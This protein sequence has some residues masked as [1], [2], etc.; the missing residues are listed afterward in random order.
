MVQRKRSQRKRSR[1][2]SQRNQTGGGFF[3]WYKTVKKD[4]M[5]QIAEKLL[6][7]RSYTN[8]TD[9]V[10]DYNLRIAEHSGI[11][12]KDGH[13][14]KSFFS[15]LGYSSLIAAEVGFAM[16]L[17]PLLKHSG[18][19]EWLSES[20][21]S[22]RNII[23]INHLQEGL[24]KLRVSYQKNKRKTQIGMA[25][26]FIAAITAI[27]YHERK[28]KKSQSKTILEVCANAWNNEYPNQKI[29]TN[30]IKKLVKKN[31]HSRTL[32]KNII[33]KSPDDIRHDSKNE[34]RLFSRQP[35]SSSKK[36]TI[37]LNYTP[38]EAHKLP[39][40]PKLAM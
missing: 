27:A 2:R 30:D 12:G 4:E 7:E 28:K 5:E 23:D 32:F 25:L 21:R 11:L 16:M 40:G 17:A 34:R 3:S 38:G 36:I 24:K 39:G 29:S 31:K 18:R 26:T 1:K 9:F 19:R 13:K 35:P 8:P 22:K 15:I 37:N 14:L 33:R 10:F 20:I 6:M